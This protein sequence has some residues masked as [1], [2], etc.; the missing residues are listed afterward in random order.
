MQKKAT[1]AQFFFSQ[2]LKLQQVD[3]PLGAKY[4]A[5]DA[6]LVQLFLQLTEKERLH[7]SDRSARIAFLSHKEDLS[8]S[9]QWRIY[10]IIKRA[11][12]IRRKELDPTAGQYA[13]ALKTVAFAIAALCHVPLPEELRAYLPTDEEEDQEDRN[14]FPLKEGIIEQL[15]V[16]V[17]QIDAAQELIICQPYGEE[18]TDQLRLRYNVPEINAQFNKTIEL[19][20]DHFPSGAI[21]QL[22]NV[23]VEESGILL[24]KRII[25]E[26]DY[27]VDVTSIAECFQPQGA[28]PYLF[29]LKKFASYENSL[30]LM[31]GNIANRFLDLLSKNPKLDFQE[32]F[33]KL[34]S[35]NP[36][37]FAD[38]KDTDIRKTYHEA[39]NHFINLQH[40]ILNE[41]PK[42]GIDRDRILLEP[43]FYSALYGIQGRLDLWQPPAEG[44]DKALIVE[45]KSGKTFMPNKYNL[46]H[47]HYV[48]T[49]L[50]GLL[51]QSVYPNYKSLAH[52]LYSK[53]QEKPLR[54]AP[55]TQ[56]KEDEALAI[57][58]QMVIM[59]R[60][61]AQLDQKSLEEYGLLHQLGPAILPKASGYTARGL[62]EFENCFSNLSELERRYFMAFCSFIA[63]EQILAKTGVEGNDRANGQAGLWL[64]QRAD[65]DEH[66]ELL[67]G[68]KLI[69]NNSEEEP[70]ILRFKRT[71]VTNPLAN[72]RQGDIAILYP[73]MGQEDNVLE[74]QIFKGSISEINAEELSFKLYSP[75]C[76]GAVFEGPQT[77]SLEH[78][79]LD[80]GFTV[81]YQSLFNFMNFHSAKR[82]LLLG[83]RAPQESS[84]PKSRDFMEP[85]L[86]QDQKRILNKALDAQDYFLLVGPPGTGKT[87]FM[88]AQ[89][90]EYLHRN[91]QENILLLAYTNRA[92]DEICEAIEEVGIDDYLR[93][94]SRYSCD[95]RFEQRMFSV[96]TEQVDS[97]KDLRATIEKHRVFVSTVSTMLNRPLLLKLKQFNTA[98]IDEASQI[99]EP[100]L[101]GLLPHFQRFVLIG[102]HKQLPAVVL[103]DKEQSA[104]S[105]EL[106][107]SIGLRNRR[108]SLFE[109]LFEQA[110]KE[111]WTCCY[112]QL[113]HQGRM[114]A[115]ISRFPSQFFYDNKLLELPEDNPVGAWQQAPLPFAA[116][117][118]APRLEQALAQHRLLFIPSQSDYLGNSKT[119]EEE[120][121]RIGELVDA[122]RNL[123]EQQGGGFAVEDLGIITPFRAQIAQIRHVL[124]QYNMGY[125]QCTIDTVERYQGGARKIILLSLAVNMGH[126]L[127]A[128]VSLSDDEQ[129][130]RKLNVALTRARQ[131]LVVL[132]NPKLLANDP[133]YAALIAWIKERDGYFIP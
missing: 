87:K 130:D 75:Q 111:A 132:G 85:H 53:L 44:D 72:F 20:Q 35:L 78:D 104:V 29:L 73:E 9:V 15:K 128:I 119:N 26:P 97:R 107:Q 42:L 23:L 127:P 1:E 12:W 57:R 93:M 114:H 6:I 94:G 55:S 86:G 88:L 99:L 36:L 115:D 81:Q 109:R 117:A 91:S 19:M 68:L 31:L 80:K 5:L 39:K 22:V 89:M 60:Q 92:V 76:S 3:Q 74:H 2:L 69:E 61:L 13:S 11:R 125:E 58:N 18:Y 113:Q 52:I 98:I 49:L 112:D 84:A 51:T 10:Q 54:L 37:G 47:N 43:S 33:K 14:P 64:S 59:E 110:Q 70:P 131:Q 40:I 103:Q 77:W 28:S 108:N 129:V 32:E 25:L 101:V 121:I 95:P 4:Q 105:D 118:D 21:L 34:F 66:F 7:F 106:L 62:E 30:P 126:Q 8:R 65:K 123:Y 122:F 116:K 46:N 56:F 100:M 50:Y 16:V 38:F 63:K 45:L 83:Q 71:E 67:A 24:P 79:M 41:F 48:Q 17:L 27:L 133:R 82:Q 120:A 90:V 124:A 102:D 96:Q